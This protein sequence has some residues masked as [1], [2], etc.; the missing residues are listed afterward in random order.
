MALMSLA[1]AGRF[2][3]T[4]TTWEDHFIYFFYLFSFSFLIFFF[5]IVV[6]FVI[7]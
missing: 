2:F 1:L 4:S 3:T 6:D 5:F 7:H